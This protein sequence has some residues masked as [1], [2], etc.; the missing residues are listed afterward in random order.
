MK[1]NFQGIPEIGLVP[2][3]PMHVDHMSI[4]QGGDSPINIVLDFWN[5]SAIGLK[6]VKVTKASGFKVDPN[7][8]K[9]ELRMSADVISCRGP[10]KGKGKVM[11]FPVQG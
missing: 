11:I 6:T 4:S 3:D 8:N 1:N 7:N 2:L 9:L 5:S 10:Y